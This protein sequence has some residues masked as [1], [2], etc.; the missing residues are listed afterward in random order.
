[1]IRWMADQ[2]LL[3]FNY[4]PE[5][6]LPK[7]DPRFDFIRWWLG[8]VLVVLGLFIIGMVVRAILPTKP[9]NN[10]G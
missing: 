1:M 3:L 10:S 5:L 8:F 4:V 2:I 9:P 6:I 7:D